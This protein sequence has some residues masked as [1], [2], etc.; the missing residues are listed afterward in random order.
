MKGW[1]R[2]RLCRKWSSLVSS[3]FLGP[4]HY[5]HSGTRHFDGSPSTIVVISI[6][7]P[8]HCLGNSF[9]GIPRRGHGSTLAS[10]T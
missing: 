4:Q 10:D 8:T 2:D 1:G 5:L 9:I 7:I 3:L 6:G